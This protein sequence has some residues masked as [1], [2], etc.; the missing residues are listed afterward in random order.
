MNAGIDRLN[1]SAF[2]DL[3]FGLNPGLSTS[4]EYDLDEDIQ[5]SWSIK[6]GA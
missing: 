5:R 1:V 2:T 3:S 4:S 6:L